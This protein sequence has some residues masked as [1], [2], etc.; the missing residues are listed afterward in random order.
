EYRDGSYLVDGRSFSHLVV[1][2]PGNEVLR[3][4]GMRDILTD[5]DHE[6]FANCDYVRTVTVFVETPTLVDRCYALSIPR[7]E[8]MR[9]ATIIF[10]GF[11][12][13]DRTGVTLVGG[14]ETVTGAELIADFHRIYPTQTGP[15]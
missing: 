6:F 3:I 11:T 2:V 9:V 10:H 14:G 12:D 5:M 8:R 1:A 15:A 7:V 4:A 13:P